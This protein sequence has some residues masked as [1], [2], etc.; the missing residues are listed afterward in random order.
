MTSH[1]LSIAVFTRFAIFRFLALLLVAA[2]LDGCTK[3]SDIDLVVAAS[4]GDST[5]VRAL[6]RAGANKEATAL[7]GLRPIEAAAQA[8]HLDIVR[9]LVE[10]GAQVNGPSGNVRT[11]LA[12]AATYKHTE[13]VEYLIS[14]GGEIRGTTEWNRGLLNTL[15]DT[16]DNRLYDLVRAQIDRE[17]RSTTN[18][19]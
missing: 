16:R 6:V 3:Q 8:G 2:L 1:N 5:Q 17:S 15:K 7:D 10:N 4:R 19:P 11:A 12:L 13:V 18:V 14:R 9:L